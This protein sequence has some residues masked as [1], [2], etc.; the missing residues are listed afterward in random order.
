MIKFYFLKGQR[1]DIHK[2]GNSDY[3]AQGT[4]GGEDGIKEECINVLVMILNW[5]LDSGLMC[6]K[7]LIL[8]Y[9]YMYFL[10]VSS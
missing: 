7:Y 6:D 4:T 9:N 3:F 8:L 10:H 2:T 5:G 1:N